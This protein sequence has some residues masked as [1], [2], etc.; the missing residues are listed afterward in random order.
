MSKRHITITRFFKKWRVYFAFLFDTSLSKPVLFLVKSLTE[1][2][3]MKPINYRK[4]PVAW[5]GVG[6]SILILSALPGGAEDVVVTQNRTFKGRVKSVDAGG[7]R[8]EM[9]GGGEVTVPR[10]SVTSLTV[11]PPPSVVNGIAAYE[12]GNLREAQKQLEKVI[13]QFQG[14]DVEWAMKGMLYCGRASLAGGEYDKADKMFDMFLAAYED[15]PMAVVA[16]IGKAAIEMARKNYEPALTK[17]REL[18]QTYDKQLKPAKDQIPYAAEIALDIG[19]CLEAQANDS[20]ALNAYLKV[21][22]LYPDDTYCPEALYRAALLYVK[23]GQPRKADALYAELIEDYANND[24]AKKAVP[25][26]AALP[27]AE[28]AAKTAAP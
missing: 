22:A 3:F 26:R 1:K 21:S 19:K 28:A 9:A 5:L 25:E 17:L 7:I 20:E 6:L 14:L 13:P 10:A 27:K 4:L 16:K 8:I 24:F 11:A 12:K 2:D 15:E 23:L 18:A